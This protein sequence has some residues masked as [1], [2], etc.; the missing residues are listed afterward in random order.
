[1]NEMR[2]YVY[3]GCCMRL[4]EVQHWG[5]GGVALRCVA[6]RSMVWHCVVW[7]GV[8]SLEGRE[9]GRTWEGGVLVIGCVGKGG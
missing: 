7:Y 4:N 5:G 9:W 2:V 1:M 6:W 8:A 3:G